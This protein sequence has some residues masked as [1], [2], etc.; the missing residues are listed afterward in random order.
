MVH[1]K[2]LMWL[3]S[4]FCLAVVVSYVSYDFGYNLKS[5][6]PSRYQSWVSSHRA[7]LFYDA[8]ENK[9]DSL[10]AECKTDTAF[11]RFFVFVDGMGAIEPV[12]YSS[13]HASSDIWSTRFSGVS[14]REVILEE[15]SLRPYALRFR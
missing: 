5:R 6:Y 12:R 3:F 2:I 10:V 1:S 8:F 14:Y 9:I 15:L 11:Y 13:L 7:E 4:F